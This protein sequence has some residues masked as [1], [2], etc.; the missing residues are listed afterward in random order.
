MPRSGVGNYSALILL[1]CPM[2][3]V[4]SDGLTN[5]SKS[6]SAV[7][8][9]GIRPDTG[10][11]GYAAE[12]RFQYPV[13]RSADLDCRAVR[14]YA[15]YISDGLEN[16]AATAYAPFSARLSR[17]GSAACNFAGKS[18]SNRRLQCCPKQGRAAGRK[19]W[20]NFFRAKKDGA[21]TKSAASPADA[22]LQTHFEFAKSVFGGQIRRDSYWQVLQ[23]QADISY[24]VIS[25]YSLS[26]SQKQ[27]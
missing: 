3:R 18:V 22:G 13:D 2:I 12:I 21:L 11:R 24:R 6:K 23:T 15:R 4:K 19:S 26:E 1:N 10:I 20:T 27:N 17:S 7:V 16:A 25:F 9:A 14:P 8:N 5:P